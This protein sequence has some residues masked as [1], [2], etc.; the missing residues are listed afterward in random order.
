VFYNQNLAEEKGD[1]SCLPINFQTKF[2]RQS[3]YKNKDCQATVGSQNRQQNPAELK[4]YIN[5]S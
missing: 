4:K 3:N 1:S 5:A 2:P